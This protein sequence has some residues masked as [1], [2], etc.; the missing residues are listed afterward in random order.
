MRLLFLHQN[1]PGQFKHLAPALAAGPANEVVAIGEE[2]A[3]A[4][5]TDLHPRLK[6][7][8][9]PKPQGASPQ[10]HHYLRG[11][12]AAVRR[13]QSVVRLLMELK[14]RGFVPDLVVAHP[15]WGEAL[16]IK[17]VFPQ[18]RLVLY[19]EFYYRAFGS[20]VNFDREYPTSVDDVFRLRIKN[21]VQ[22][23]SIE[24]ADAAVSPTQWQAAQFPTRFRERI[25]VMHD[26]IDTRRVAPGDAQVV[27]P[28]GRVLT[29][30]DKVVTYV[31]R[32]LE[33][34]RGFHTFMRAV[35]AI[36]ASH[37]D[38]QIVVV[39]GD[40][41]SY[42]RPPPPGETYRERQLK[43]IAGRFDPARLHFLGRVPY[44]TYLDVL[45]VSS[46]HLYLTYPFVLSW[47]LIEAMACGCLLVASRT[48]PVEEVL[49]DGVNARL[50][51][52]FSADEL[53]QRT[54]EALADEPAAGHQALRRQA[55]ADAVA[56]YDLASV[57]LPR[58]LD[59]VN[60]Q[61]ARRTE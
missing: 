4:R 21:T 20:D 44:D 46:A 49:R 45:R 28:G 56:G 11:T 42:S 27:L 54:L 59:F 8:A 41:V 35:P 40:E 7:L 31:S 50:V 19:L 24:Q 17:D 60:A 32:N 52:F 14:A 37:P 2:Q 39:G 12:E 26:G 25:T 6:L 5:C 58:L 18:T 15:G 1:F 23:L 55:R 51:D 61:A 22:L 10:T 30:R 48:P 16:F 33:P 36:H 43:E 34:Y 29:R 3:I 57:C 53:A 13:G 38:A 47:S 9:Y